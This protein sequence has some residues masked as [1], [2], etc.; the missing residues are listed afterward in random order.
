MAKGYGLWPGA[1]IALYAPLTSLTPAAWAGWRRTVGSG[2]HIAPLDTAP[3][4]C[5][6]R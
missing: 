5:P 3:P 6:A 1:E 2:A 4:Y